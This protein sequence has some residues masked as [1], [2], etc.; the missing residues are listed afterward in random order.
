MM[1]DFEALAIYKHLQGS[2]PT[3]ESDLFIATD[4]QFK[5]SHYTNVFKMVETIYGIKIN[6]KTPK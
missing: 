2:K 6:N 3:L 4:N 1:Y 5:L